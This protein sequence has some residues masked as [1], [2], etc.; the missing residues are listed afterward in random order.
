MNE[1]SYIYKFSESLN[2][3]NKNSMGVS[4]SLTLNQMSA[5][6]FFLKNSQT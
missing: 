5:G 3:E 2:S 4:P 1:S 6:L